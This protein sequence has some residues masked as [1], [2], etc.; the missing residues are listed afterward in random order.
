MF[1]HSLK[2]FIR[3]DLHDNRGVYLYMSSENGNTIF[4]T[5]IHVVLLHF[6]LLLI[7]LRIILKF[8]FFLEPQVPQINRTFN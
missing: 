4:L 6:L 5:I 3:N 7:T 8:L 2:K 1:S